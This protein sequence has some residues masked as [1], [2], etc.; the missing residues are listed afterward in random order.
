MSTRSERTETIA[1]L[2]KEFT[3]ATGIYMTDFTGIN[4]EK[5]TKFRADMKNSGVKYLVVKN[6]LARI[7]FEKCGL[8]Q[9]IPYLKSP[10]GMAITKG[11]AVT[12]AKVIKDFRKNNKNLLD[13]KVAFIDGNLFSGDEAARIADL[14]SREVLLSQLLSCLKAPM[15]GL[16]GSLNGILTNF[17][18][19]LQA[20]VLK[21]ESE[22][23]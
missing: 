16:A 15:T 18:G 8:D 23:N 14:P 6:T 17:A 12:P 13:L 5:I 9:L 2:E 7:A 1:V 10:I 21:K 22:S 11:D 19:T 4:V 3:D 20:V